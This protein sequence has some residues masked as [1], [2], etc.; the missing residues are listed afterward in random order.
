ME[1]ETTNIALYKAGI[2][3]KAL[4]D[5]LLQLYLHDLSE[6]MHI[7]VGPNGKYEQNISSKYVSS[8]DRSAYIIHAEYHIIGFVLV[9]PQGDVTKV[10]DLFVLNMWR[11]KGVGST[12][13]ESLLS[14]GK[15]LVCK[16][17]QKNELAKYFW[18]NIA[19]NPLHKISSHEEG[20]LVNLRVDY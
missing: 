14:H 20:G 5:N 16:F 11:G 3:D 7:E 1:V 6:F 10:R 15:P 13:V 12:V 18:N 17:H 9:E 4:L 19:K 8:F 2:N